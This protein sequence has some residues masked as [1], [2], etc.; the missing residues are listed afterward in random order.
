[1]TIYQL[2]EYSGEFD[3]YTDNLVGTYALKLRAELEMEKLI[4]RNSQ[5]SKCNSCPIIYC[6]EDCQFDCDDTERCDK[7]RI[8]EATKL[9]D[10][11]LPSTSIISISNGMD[12]FETLN[13]ENYSYA[14]EYEYEI[15]EV[16]VIE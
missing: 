5:A 11:F 8:E 7:Y 14:Y 12:D 15:K 2:H 6:P 3:S 16:E 9:C 1:M 13:C 10:R 4:E